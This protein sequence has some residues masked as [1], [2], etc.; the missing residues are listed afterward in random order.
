MIA[1]CQQ[2]MVG[3]S[4]AKPSSSASEGGVSIAAYF[5]LFGSMRGKLSSSPAS[6]LCLLLTKPG[7]GEAQAKSAHCPIT[8]LIPLARILILCRRC[9]LHSWSL[10]ASLGVIVPGPWSRSSAIPSRTLLH[11]RIASSSSVSLLTPITLTPSFCLMV[12]ERYVSVGRARGSPE[13]PTFAASRS[14]FSRANLKATT[15]NLSP[16]LSVQS[17]AAATACR[18]SSGAGCQLPIAPIGGL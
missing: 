16:C 2:E 8:V 7:S 1:C 5:A 13:A 12:S 3:T 6:H 11:T 4:S 9:K 18:S 15:S 17:L 10:T 14:Q